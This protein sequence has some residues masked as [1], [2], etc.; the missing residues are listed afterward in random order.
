MISECPVC[1]SPNSALPRKVIN[2]ATKDFVDCPLCLEGPRPTPPTH[3]T[4][5]GLP[6]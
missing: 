6:H 1:G 4:V 2:L 5:Q 3:D